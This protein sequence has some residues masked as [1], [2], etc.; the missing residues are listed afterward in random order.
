MLPIKAKEKTPSLLARTLS[1]FRAAEKE[2]ALARI[3]P[4]YLTHRCARSGEEFLTEWRKTGALFIFSRTIMDAETTSEAKNRRAL[5]SRLSHDVGFDL[6]EFDYVSQSCAICGDD[7]AQFFCECG[8]LVCGAR[9]RFT[10]TGKLDFFRCD[11]S[12]GKSCG[13]FASPKKIAANEGAAQSRKA[14][15]GPSGKAL[16]PPPRLIEKS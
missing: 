8:K 12:C 16:P 7:H 13:V 15:S 14:L 1:R 11:P 9:S 6:S 10:K 2:R 3:K 4:R 5:F